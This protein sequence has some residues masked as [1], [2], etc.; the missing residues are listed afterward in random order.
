MR[1]YPEYSSPFCQVV[2]HI[3]LP[4]DYT[5]AHIHM[6]S[7]KSSICLVAISSLASNPPPNDSIVHIALFIFS[8]RTCHPSCGNPGATP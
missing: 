1:T 6:H 5:H 8:V 7:I 4:S 2:N 3:L